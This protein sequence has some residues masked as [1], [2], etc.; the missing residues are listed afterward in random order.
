MKRTIVVGEGSS[1]TSRP[2]SQTPWIKWI[3]TTKRDERY[4]FTEP[5]GQHLYVMVNG[6][7][8]VDTILFNQDEVKIA[9]F[10]GDLINQLHRVDL[11]MPQGHSFYINLLEKKNF[12]RKALA[13]EQRL[14]DRFSLLVTTTMLTDIVQTVISA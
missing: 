5:R 12:A 6:G 2:P 3:K 4:L 8:V 1:Y 10:L 11:T 14:V 9:F 13:L 7:E